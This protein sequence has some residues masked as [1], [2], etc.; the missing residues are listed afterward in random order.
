MKSIKACLALAVMVVVC[1]SMASAMPL[2]SSARGVIPADLQQL[3]SVDYRAMKDSPT[4]AALKQ[5]L[6]AAQENLQQFEGALSECL[7]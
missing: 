5:Q 3:I 6:M 2:N 7:S 4:A 1:M